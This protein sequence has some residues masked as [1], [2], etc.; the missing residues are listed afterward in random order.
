M[1]GL[2][3]LVWCVNIPEGKTIRVEMFKFIGCKNAYLNL[4]EPGDDLPLVGVDC[5]FDGGQTGRAFEVQ[6]VGAAWRS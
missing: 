1:F 3:E 4:R 5:S 2:D 6:P